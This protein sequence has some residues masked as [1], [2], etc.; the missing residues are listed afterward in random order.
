MNETLARLRSTGVHLSVDDFGT[1]YSSLTYL[2]RLPVDQ[3]K[4]DKSFVTELDGSERDRAIVRSMID[5]GRNLGLEV[6][7]EGVSTASARQI[8]AELGCRL[9]QGYLIARP[10]GPEELLRR[11]SASAGAAGPPGSPAIPAPRAQL[12]DGS[13][14]PSAVPG[15]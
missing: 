10:V 4:I 1:G 11:L 5:L 9:G 7:A 14:L 6:V 2:S 8:L 3:M 12:R 13:A 15:S